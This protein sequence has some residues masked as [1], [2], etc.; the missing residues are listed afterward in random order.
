LKSRVDATWDS[1]PPFGAFGLTQSN[2]L[3]SARRPEE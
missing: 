1:T 2:W 3:K